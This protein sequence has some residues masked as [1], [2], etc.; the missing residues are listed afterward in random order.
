MECGR[1]CV[2]FNCPSGPNEIITNGID[3]LIAK[4]GDIDDLADK[5]EWMITH[6]Y[7][8]HLMGERASLS[9]KKYYI[10]PIMKQWINLFNKLLDDQ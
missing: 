10:E 3:G 7:E 6:E 2:A 8:R 4:N 5:I 1:P 9:A